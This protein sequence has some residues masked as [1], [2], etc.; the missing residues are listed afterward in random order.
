L[1]VPVYNKTIISAGL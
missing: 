1:P